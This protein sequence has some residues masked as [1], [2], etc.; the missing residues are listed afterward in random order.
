MKK[1][2]GE[3]GDEEDHHEDLAFSLENQYGGF[4]GATT[5]LGDFS[6]LRSDLSLSHL[7]GG[8]QQQQQQKVSEAAAPPPETFAPPRDPTPEPP[9]SQ[10]PPDVVEEGEVQRGATEEEPSEWD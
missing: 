10:A 2:T 4:A 8:E 7:E 6:M 1:S 3:N 9:A 5:Q